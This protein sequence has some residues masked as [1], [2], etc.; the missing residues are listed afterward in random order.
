MPL[1]VNFL[2]RG[3]LLV[4]GLVAAASMLA[5]FALVATAWTLRA[6]WC[7]LTGRPVTPFGVRMDAA[8][9]FQ[10]MM[11]RA[12]PTD[13]ASR[14]PRAD[15]AGGPGRRLEDVTDVQPRPPL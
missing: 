8:R 1:I 4:L 15:A 7:R 2:L 12:P 9:A 13:R 5:V 10:D 11:R 3:L 6:L 14:T